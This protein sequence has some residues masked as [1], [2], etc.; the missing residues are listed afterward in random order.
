MHIEYKGPHAGSPHAPNVHVDAEREAAHGW[1]F[2][3]T[4]RAGMGQATHHTVSLSYRDHD[5]W[6]GGKMSPSHLI[7][8][9][10]AYVLRKRPEVLP[11]RFDAARVRYWFPAF[12]E[13][14]RSGGVG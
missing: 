8:Q 6:T 7:E 14:M 13:E 11:L 12:D 9:V 3:V 5:M 2:E 10:V 1:E 4:V